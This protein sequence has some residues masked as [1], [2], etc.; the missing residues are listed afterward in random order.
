MLSMFTWIIQVLR[1]SRQEQDPHYFLNMV[2]PSVYLLLVFMSHHPQLDDAL[3]SKMG[4]VAHLLSSV[5]LDASHSDNNYNP[6]SNA[7]SY[8]VPL[9]IEEELQVQNKAAQPK[10]AISRCGLKSARL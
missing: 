3:N 4:H 5:H 1:E 6:F 9:H 2:P 8:L 7:S 10:L